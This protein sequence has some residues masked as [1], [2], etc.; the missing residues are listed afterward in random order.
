MF[1]VSAFMQSK[2]FAQSAQCLEANTLASYKNT[3][4]GPYEYAVFIFNL[5]T[6]FTYNVSS[7]S[8][9]FDFDPSGDP[10]TIPGS[11]FRKITFSNVGWQCLSANNVSIIPGRKIMGLKMI[12]QFEGKISLVVGFRKNVKLKSTYTYDSGNYKYVVMKFR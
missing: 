3:K 9:P 5:P 12:E 4:V 7:V 6:E 2:N 10:V 1:L 8:P 11:K